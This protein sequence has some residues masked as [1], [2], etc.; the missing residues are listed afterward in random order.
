MHVA[1]RRRTLKNINLVSC[2][3]L[4]LQ[5]AVEVEEYAIMELYSLSLTSRI[6]TAGDV[7]K[8]RQTKSLAE[9][10][11]VEQINYEQPYNLHHI[12]SLLNS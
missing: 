8:S 6:E 10:T 11:A 7:N 2:C 4:D 5:L 3:L 9:L 12:S 1:H